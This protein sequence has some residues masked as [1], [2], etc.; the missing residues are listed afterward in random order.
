MKEFKTY[1][2]QIEL[3]KTRGLKFE[4]EEFD[5]NKLQEDNYYSI[6]NG[7]KDLFLDKEDKYFNISSMLMDTQEK[8]IF[9]FDEWDY[10]FNNNLFDD[11]WFGFPF[12]GYADKAENRAEK[13][14]YGHHANNLMK[15]DIKEMKDGYELEIDLP[16]FK[17]DEV[18]AEL[19]DGYLTVSAAKGLD[20]DEQEKETGRYIRR[21]RYAGNLSR[22]FYIG[23]VKQ[24][25]VKAAFKNGILSISV[26]KEDKKAKEEKK[27]ITIGE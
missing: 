13:K 19:K 2:E 6:I 10:I 12:Y 1:E 14:L 27:Y 23:D 18:T 8:F 4:N 17:K 7:Y 9:I 25:D 15:T 22:S 11:D 5:L 26:P 24:E 20:Q 16:G 3:L 21:E